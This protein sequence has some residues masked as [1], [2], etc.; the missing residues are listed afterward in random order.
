MLRQSR[1]GIRAFIAEW[2]QRH[3]DVALRRQFLLYTFIGGIATAVDWGSFYLLNQQA[4]I[5]YKLAVTLSFTFGAITNYVLN[6]TITFKDKTKQIGAQIGIY[7]I[8]SVLSLLMSVLLMFIQIDL[9]A[10]HAMVAR[11]IT[12]GIMLCCNFLMHKLLTFNQRV[13]LRVSNL[14]KNDKRHK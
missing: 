10:V 11:V 13:C 2:T 12:T 8:I 9:L 14:L 3:L 1:G 7:I 6:K 4:G 5:D